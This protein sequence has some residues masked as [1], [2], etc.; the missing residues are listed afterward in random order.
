MAIKA[1]KSENE[2]SKG[3]AKILFVKDKLTQKEI[4]VKTGKTEATIS[5]WVTAGNWEKERK[6]FLLTRQEQM[7]YLLDELG[8]LNAAI[9]KKPEG[10]RYADSKEGDVRR[11]LIKDIKELETST[12]KPEAISACIALLEFIR[13]VDLV[14][15][16]Q[17]AP[18]IDGFVKSIM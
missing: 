4:A 18:Y 11:K 14:I 7:S 10:A 17:L 5:K 1:T 13:K 3:Y 8:E 9:R 12:N 2:K 16:Q 6:N 15:C